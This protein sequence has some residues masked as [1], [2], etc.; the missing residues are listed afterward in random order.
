MLLAD[1]HG[2]ASTVSTEPLW[3]P[4]AKIAGRYLAPFL[5][6]SFDQLTHAP[7]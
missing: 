3:W 6:G 1:C 4:P 5:A 2:H 7:T